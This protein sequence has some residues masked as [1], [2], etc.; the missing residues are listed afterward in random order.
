MPIIVV[1]HPLFFAWEHAYLSASYTYNIHSSF[2]PPFLC[3]VV[4]T[5]RG[6]DILPTFATGLRQDGEGGVALK[7]QYRSNERCLFHP[8]IMRR[9]RGS[10]APLCSGNYASPSFTFPPC[11]TGRRVVCCTALWWRPHGKRPPFLL[12][13]TISVHHA[14][15]VP[16][17][18][19]GNSLRRS[20]M[21]RTAEACMSYDTP[22]SAQ[23]HALSPPSRTHPLKP[24]TSA[25]AALP[26]W[27]HI[28]RPQ[29]VPYRGFYVSLQ[30]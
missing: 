11:S 10:F 4:K 8:P 17:G 24:C 5:L 16:Y 15:M 3:A 26:C 30:P 19:G 25:S 13:S 14:C 29:G 28:A 9:P 1:A 27:C 18:I 20:L 6:V 7:T 12:S 22:P 21:C 2:F 23:R